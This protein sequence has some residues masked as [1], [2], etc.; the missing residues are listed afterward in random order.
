VTEPTPQETP[1]EE[2]GWVVYFY[3][4]YVTRESP[5][6]NAYVR[7]VRAAGST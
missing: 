3:D 5:N 2:R 4:G 1:P 7:A 6:F